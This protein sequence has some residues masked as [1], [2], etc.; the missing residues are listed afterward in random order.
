MFLRVNS[1]CAP[2]RAPATGCQI[3]R[4]SSISRHAR[5]AEGPTFARTVLCALT[6]C[7][8][9]ADFESDPRSGDGLTER[10]KAVRFL[11]GSPS[12]CFYPFSFSIA[13]TAVSKMSPKPIAIDGRSRSRVAAT[14]ALGLKCM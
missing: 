10:V 6:V 12:N 14:T 4:R 3:A 7:Q 9:L 13:E 5:G 8:S 2:P 1:S 11:R